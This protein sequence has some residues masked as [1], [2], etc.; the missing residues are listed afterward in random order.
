[1]RVDP[2]DWPEA[3]DFFEDFVAGRSQ[4]AAR[5]NFLYASG[6]IR[7]SGDGERL[8]IGWAGAH[9]IEFVYRR[10]RDGIWAFLPVEGEYRHMA[11][12]ID[13]FVKG[14]SS[15]QIRV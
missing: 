10:D 1:M 2:K 3:A 9:G 7:Q 11:D 8:Y 14:W 6:E 13:A 4:R 15:G 12:T 5:Y